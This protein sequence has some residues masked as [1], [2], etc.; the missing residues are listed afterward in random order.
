[1]GRN[2]LTFSGFGRRRGG[3]KRNTRLFIISKFLLYSFYFFL[4]LVLSAV[5]S[6]FWASR[7][8]PTPGSLSNPNLHDSTKIVDRNDIVLFS[9]YKDYNRMYVK[10]D[11]IPKSLR[12]ATIVTEDKDFYQNKLG[13]SM[14]GY[15][16]AIRDL[17]FHGTVTGG[18]TITQQLVK[19]VL[20]SPE[21]NITRKLKE[22]VLAIQVGKRYSKDEIL[23]MY[24]N[25]I[26]YGSTAIGV[27]AASNLYFGKH[28][29]DLTPAESAFLA[30]L[31]QAP[32][33]Y[34]PFSANGKA[35]LSRTK[36]VLARLEE[37]GY[38][39][40]KQADQEYSEVENFKFSSTDYNIKA[41]HF[42][43]YV[44]EQLIK[45]FGEQMLE[46]GNLYVK[47]SLDYN[48][49]KKAEEI[50]KDELDKL[51]GYHVGNGAVMVINPKTGE[52]LSMVGSRD[53]FDASNS[54]NFNTALALRQ[55]GSSLKP[56]LYADAFEKGYTPSSVLMDVKTDFP[57]DDLKN[58]IYTPVDYDGKYRGP[59]QI[60]FALANSINIPAVKMLARVGIKSFMERAFDMGI[61]N[62][63][64]TS[65]NM[66]D[67]G[68]SLV[69][70]GREAS[71][72]QIVSAYGVLANQGIKR[73]PV[74]ILEVRDSHGNTLYK[75]KDVSGVRELSV[76]A[77]FLI[78]HILLDNNARSLVFGLNSWLVVSGKTVAVKTGTTDDKRDN[79]TIG[80]TPSYVTGV[81]V[82][83]NDNSPMN[84][85]IASGVTGAAP[86]WN[87][88]MQ[89]IL[90][91]QKSEDFQKPDNVIVAQIDANGGGLALNG[92][93]T[94]T[95]YFIKGT[96]P[97]SASSVYKK[98]KVSKHDNG[99]LANQ[100]EITHG[101]YDEKDFI[102]FQESDPVSK[103]NVNRWQQGIDAWVKEN[104]KDDPKYFPPTSLS[105]YKYSAQAPAATSIPTAT[106]SAQ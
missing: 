92:E 33:Y 51:K 30:G 99:K 23:E 101:D 71:L 56:I 77:A 19:T 75:N 12:D 60:R 16:R 68:L 43:M 73:D 5:I 98:I 35:Y 26:P 84:P 27:E 82:G 36:H 48:I 76:E 41:P 6:L 15:L 10:L 83:N 55:P 94:R 79:W 52:V 93:P 2:K 85:A 37:E 31:P 22:L 67:V 39:S 42:V 9:F 86:I 95:E 8:I 40:K 72:A 66:K 63:Q 47:T 53:Y 24:L 50:L 17:I 64:P 3:V 25:D 70:G 91:D 106:S 44:R 45:M 29:K 87:K 21:R 38:I 58:P 103:D 89:A 96:E 14:F 102:V 20:L 13:F 80:Y 88:V 34:S 104:H 46:Q 78:S 69:L 11:D 100:D 18:S 97:T 61:E 57:T 4:F 28:V 59:V 49:E 1:M 62:W 54:G 65:Q 81:W 90:K 32:S 7:N 74:S 105:D